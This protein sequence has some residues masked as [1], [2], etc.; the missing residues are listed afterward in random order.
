M[1]VSQLL[2]PRVVC[3][4]TSRFKKAN[5]MTASFVTPIS[6]SPMI[7]GVSIAPKR[8]THEI[9]EKSGWFGLNVCSKDDKE[10]A[11][12]CGSCSGRDVDKSKVF[13]FFGSKKLM[14]KGFPITMECKV[15]NSVREGD[16]TFFIGEV[17]EYKVN[18]DINKFEPLLHYFGDRFNV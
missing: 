5:V 7:L 4:V 8:F 1:R 14:I 16:H 15:V 10:V 6:F 17:K 2:F 3:L 11:L 13:E 12:F 18:V 9:I